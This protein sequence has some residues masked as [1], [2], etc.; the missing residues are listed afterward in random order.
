MDDLFKVK[1][2]SFIYQKD[3]VSS[4]IRHYLSDKVTQSLSCVVGHNDTPTDYARKMTKT[5]DGRVFDTYAQ[6]PIQTHPKVPLELKQAWTYDSLLNLGIGYRTDEAIPHNHKQGQSLIYD[7]LLAKLILNDKHAPMSAYSGLINFSSEM[8]IFLDRRSVIAKQSFIGLFS[9]VRVG[10]GSLYDSNWIFHNALWYDVLSSNPN[11]LRH[12]RGFLHACALAMVV[13]QES[14]QQYH[15]V[16]IDELVEHME[17]FLDLRE[18]PDTQ[19]SDIRRFISAIEHYTVGI[20]PHA[21]MASL[22]TAKYK[23]VEAMFGHLNTTSNASVDVKPNPT[24]DIVLKAI[25]QI[26]EL[27]ED[28]ISTDAT[29]DA[30]IEK[31]DQTLLGEFLHTA[32]KLHPFRGVVGLSGTQRKALLKDHLF[33][34]IV[35]MRIEILKASKDPAK[36]EYDDY[37]RNKAHILLLGGDNVHRLGLSLVASLLE[38]NIKRNLEHLTER[39]LETALLLS[40]AWGMLGYDKPGKMSSA[41]RTLLSDNKIRHSLRSTLFSFIEIINIPPGEIP[42]NILPCDRATFFMQIENLCEYLATTP[43]QEEIT[44]FFKIMPMISFTKKLDMWDNILWYAPWTM[45]EQSSG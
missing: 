40:W 6:Y 27:L 22:Y 43:T 18:S 36:N 37:I 1:E 4:L 23:E 16:T 12:F 44:E 31:Y 3:M 10:V 39:E 35:G 26:V 19:A 42:S 24:W 7:A 9:R 32:Q 38:D 15:D 33:M 29:I 20:E 8:Q 17:R 34:A 14:L 11:R 45:V 5:P 28:H 25:P 41:W 2:D 30:I 21:I 13:S